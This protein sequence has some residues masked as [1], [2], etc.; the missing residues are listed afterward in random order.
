MSRPVYF[1]PEAAEELAEAQA[2]Y[3]ARS[4]GLGDRF[5]D[6]IDALSWRIGDAPHRFP[7]VHGTIQRALLGRFP[8]ALFFRDEADGVYVIACLHTSRHPERWRRR[9]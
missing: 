6:A 2:W 7:H 1:L 8:Y 5:F 9:T 3:D 4:A